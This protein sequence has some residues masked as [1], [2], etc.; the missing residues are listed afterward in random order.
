M[1]HSNTVPGDEIDLIDLWIIVVKHIKVFLGVFFLVLIAA[2]VFVAARKPVYAYSLALQIGGLRA[3]NGAFSLVDDP[4]AVMDQLKNATIPSALVEY[5]D[6]HPG[7]DPA[8]V[9]VKVDNA[10]KSDVI[11]LSINGDVKREALAVAILN[12]IAA[13]VDANHASSLQQHVELTRK[14]LDNQISDV[15]TQLSELEKNRQRVST[16]GS[17]ESKALTL[18]LINDQISRLQS[19]LANL[20]QQRDVALVSDVRFTHPLAPPQRSVNTIGLGKS[21]LVILGFLGAIFLALC[22]TFIS[23]MILL[24]RERYSAARD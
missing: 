21:Y 18:L 10:D 3:S 9:K 15:E 23:H 4:G 22:A 12:L 5:A 11:V 6:S 2:I 24:T 16:S 14:F 1:N 17:A 20:K 13:K 19:T 7:F 8:S